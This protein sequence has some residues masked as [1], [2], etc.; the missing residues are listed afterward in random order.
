[1]SNDNADGTSM[2]YSGLPPGGWFGEGTVLK[3]EARR[4][5]VVALATRGSP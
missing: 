2:T 1:M 3:N 4:Y 5:D